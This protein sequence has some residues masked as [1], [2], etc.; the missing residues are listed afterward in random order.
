[1]IQISK[2]PASPEFAFN[3]QIPDSGRM[4]GRVLHVQSKHRTGVF[5]CYLN[6]IDIL[7]FQYINTKVYPIF[8]KQYIY[9]TKYAKLHYSRMYANIYIGIGSTCMYKG[10]LNNSAFNKV[11]VARSV[12]HRT[13]DLRAVSSNR[14]VGKTFSFCILS[15]STSTWQADWS[16]TSEIKHDIHPRYIGA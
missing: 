9:K 11:R 1:M 2:R 14:T 5:L 3:M 6:N 16:H 10:H 4:F 12:E 13:T 8:T 7:V 15:L